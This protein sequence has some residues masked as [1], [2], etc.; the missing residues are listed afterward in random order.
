[1]KK[2]VPLAV[3]VV[4]VL[5]YLVYV[6]SSDSGGLLTPGLVNVVGLFAVVIGVVAAGAILRRG[7]PVGEGSSR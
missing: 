5:A 7:G 2:W 3:I 4:A 1:L 6:L